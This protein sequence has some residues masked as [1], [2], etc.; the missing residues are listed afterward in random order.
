MDVTAGDE[1]PKRVLILTA[2]AGFGHRSA[3]NAIAAALQEVYGALCTVDIVHPLSDRRVPAL[4]RHLQFDYDKLIRTMPDLY[5]VGY[6][7]SDKT[8]LSKVIDGA[9]VV[10]MFEVMADLLRQYRPHGVVLT[11]PLYQ[12]PLAAACGIIHHR[13]FLLT[14]VTDL[15]TVHRV[16]FN[17]TCDLCVVPTEAVRDLALEYHLPPHKVKIVGIPVHPNFAR[18]KQ[19]KVTSRLMLGWRPEL[20][21]VLVVGSKRVRNLH[22]VLRV[23]NHAGLPLQLAVVAGGDE[24]LYADLSDTTWHVE[25]HVY[26]FVQN[27]PA[28]MHAADC[29]VSKAG[30]LI[31]SEALA[32]GLPMVLVDVLPGQETG[33]ADH[34]INNGAGELADTPIA[35]LEILYHWLEHGGQQLAAR[36][37]NAQHLGRPHAAYDIADLVW[38]AISPIAEEI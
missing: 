17:R 15:A 11:Y 31:V 2:D 38:E 1:N 25:A 22:D 6:K 26:R 21:T 36:A 9:L 28:L 30:G 33:N 16:W 24:A 19:D 5:R 12:A 27:M 3:A 20:T 37:R 13:P 7:T 4:L 10:M 35:A 29:V 23:L 34:V 32:C 18:W 8:A 14:V